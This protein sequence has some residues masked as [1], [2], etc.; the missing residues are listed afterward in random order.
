MVPHCIDRS[1]AQS[2]GAPLALIDR[3]LSVVFTLSIVSPYLFS[4]L[5]KTTISFLEISWSYLT[6]LAFWVSFSNLNKTLD[7]SDKFHR[8]S[9]VPSHISIE[10]LFGSWSRDR[11]APLRRRERVLGQ[12]VCNNRN[13]H[14]PTDNLVRNCALRAPT[15]S[16][17]WQQNH[18]RPLSR[19]HRVGK[20]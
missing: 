20:S 7:K 17:P 12:V 11:A 6:E 1:E 4:A 8:L 19:A 16:K 13:T 18:Q 9:S 3:R 5:I 2:C 14:R 15:A 10:L